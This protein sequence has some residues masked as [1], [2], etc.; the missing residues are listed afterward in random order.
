MDNERPESPDLP[1]TLT[2]DVQADPPDLQDNTADLDRL[3]QALRRALS[4]RG[5]DRP[6]VIPYRFM[7][8]VG[9]AFRDA[10]FRGQAAVNVLVDRFECVDFSA[11]SL[12]VLPAMALDLG[13]THLEATLIDL[14]SG[15]NLKQAQ[16]P[17]QVWR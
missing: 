11:Q 5:Q 8:R 17:D 14:Q 4:A 12:P 9:Q 2:I 16:W 13:T 15:N 10:G 3:R 7:A 1:L 6:V